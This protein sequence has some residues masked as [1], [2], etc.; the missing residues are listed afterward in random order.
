[1]DN[2]WLIVHGSWLKAHGWWLK[3][4]G[5][6]LVAHGSWLMAL[7]HGQGGQP[8]LGVRGGAHRSM[9]LVPAR[10]LAPGPGRPAP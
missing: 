7:A 9:G 1:M 8:G 6:W 2:Q 4:R 10:P 3:A 5:S